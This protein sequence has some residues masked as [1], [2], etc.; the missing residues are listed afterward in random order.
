MLLVPGG[1]QFPPDSWEVRRSQLRRSTEEVARVIIV[2]KW[3]RG[4]ETSRMSHDGTDR[5]VEREARGGER[6]CVCV[7]VC[8]CV[9]LVLNLYRM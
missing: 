9:G 7:C 4:G 1:H 2:V 5:D 3:R 8:V 6:V